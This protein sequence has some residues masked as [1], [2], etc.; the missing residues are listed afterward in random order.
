MH[1]KNRNNNRKVFYINALLLYKNIQKEQ[2]QII[3]NS[4]KIHIPTTH[5]SCLRFLCFGTNKNG[6]NHRHALFV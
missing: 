3:F 5:H 2:K 1:Y 4:E 6:R